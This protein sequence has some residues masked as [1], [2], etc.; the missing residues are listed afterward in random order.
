MYQEFPP[1]ANSRKD[2]LESWGVR[3]V[4]YP[5]PG[6]RQFISGKRFLQEDQLELS[7]WLGGNFGALH[8]RGRLKVGVQWQPDFHDQTAFRTVR[9]MHFSAM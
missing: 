9:G 8:R 4:A 7:D 6:W 1:R 3:G 5:R 2:L